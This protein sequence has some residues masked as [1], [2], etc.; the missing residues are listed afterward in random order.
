MGK[1]KFKNLLD[2]IGVDETFTKP[3]KKERAFTHVKDNIPMKRHYN[4][5]ADL[6]HLPTD[7]NGY[8]YLL[9]VVDLASNAFDI[10]PLKTKEPKEVLEA[11]QKMYTREYIKNHIHQSRQTAELNSRACFRNISMTNQYITQLQDHTDTSNYPMLK[12]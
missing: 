4:Y 3:V 11:M 12:A 2:D 6:L 1:S 10:E 7:K 5:M 8:Q 9:V